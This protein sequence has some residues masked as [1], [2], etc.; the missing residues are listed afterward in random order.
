MFPHVGHLQLKIDTFF[1]ILNFL[2]VYELPIGGTACSSAART[3]IR[4]SAVRCL[5]RF[6]FL[7]CKSALRTREYEDVSIESG[8]SHVQCLSTNRHGWLIRDNI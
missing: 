2:S 6:N 7:F 5:H 1:Q 8:T 3:F 4:N